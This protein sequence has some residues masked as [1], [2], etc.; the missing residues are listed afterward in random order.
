MSWNRWVFPRMTR[1]RL[2]VMPLDM[3]KNV[4]FYGPQ[5]LDD[6][7]DESGVLMNQ[8]NELPD[9]AG[10]SQLVTYYG[11]TNSS[12]VNDRPGEP[13]YELHFATRGQS[14]VGHHNP[15]GVWLGE[16][17]NTM[18]AMHG[19]NGTEWR[20]VAVY[21][22]HA[23]WPPFVEFWP[24]RGKEIAGEEIIG[25]FKFGLPVH[26]KVLRTGKIFPPRKSVE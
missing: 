21:G 3:S 6:E 25:N 7:I 13:D 10:A 20:N 22:G 8:D 19:E 4:D 12:L 2:V 11:L 18:L 14:D 16:I 17:G 26:T 15:P 9:N 24:Y 23:Q 5:S 1:G